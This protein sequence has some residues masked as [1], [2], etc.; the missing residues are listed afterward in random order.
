MYLLQQGK[1]HGTM[2]DKYNSTIAAIVGWFN[3]AEHGY[4][5]TISKGTTLYSVPKEQVSEQWRRH[6]NCHK[7]QIR[8][9]GWWTFMKDYIIENCKKGYQHNKYEQQARSVANE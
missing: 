1:G 4:A 8:F 6:E 5:V 2:S 3:D 7:E 9:L